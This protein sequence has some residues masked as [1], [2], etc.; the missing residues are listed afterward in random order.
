MIRLE[1]IIDAYYVTR[2]NKRRSA[3][4]VEFELHWQAGCMHL[5]H[6]IVNRCFQPKAYMFVVKRPKVREVFASDMQTRILH[7]CLD[8]R[9]R[10]IMEKLMSPHIFNNRKGKGQKAFQNALIE[11]IYRET[12]GYTRDAWIIKLDL[13]ACFPNINLD[14]AFN[15]MERLLIDHYHGEDKDELLYILRICVYSFPTLHCEVRA[16]PAE[17]RLIPEGKSVFKKPIGIGASLGFLLWQNAV[18][19]YFGD[20]CAWM[21]SMGVTYERYVDD[22]II[23]TRNKA[24]TLAYVIPELRRRLARLGASLNENKFYCQHAS[25][26]VEALGVHIKMDRVYPNRRLQGRASKKV[27]EY[28]K[29]ITAE[30]AWKVLSSLNSYF[31]LMKTTNGYSLASGLL[32]KLDGRWH[33][34]LR[35]NRSRVCLEPVTTKRNYIINKYK[36]REH[37]TDREG[38][39]FAET[40]RTAV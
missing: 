6:D 19:W 21:E 35:F 5:Y 1:D 15:Q 7:H 8:M 18:N 34:Y 9:M 24:V 13:K 40:Q 27:R 10:P 25:K 12:A 29:D 26:G 20:V 37:D 22:W 39:E 17:V 36:L 31:G 14:I 3:D 28:N 4:Q 38:R 2:R 16:T 11:D 30:A 33:E 23:V 32:R